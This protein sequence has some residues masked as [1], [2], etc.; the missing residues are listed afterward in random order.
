MIYEYLGDPH[1]GRKFETGVPLHRRGEREAL[2]FENFRQALLNATAEVHVTMGDLFD[3]FIVPPEVV[4]FAVSAYR[5]AAEQNP[6][7]TYVILRGNHDVSKN[8]DKASSWDI[9]VAFMRD[10]GNIWTIDDTPAVYENLLFIPY[11]P[12]NYDHLED[13]LGPE[14]DTAF[15]HFDIVDFG[16]PN[17]APTELLAR[18]GVKTLVNGHDH[19]AR[20]LDRHRVHVVVTGSMEPYTHAEDP[21]GRL[22]VTVSLGDLVGLDVRQKNVRVLLKPG[23]TLPEDLDCLSI[24]AK[25]VTVD[26]TDRTVDTTEFDNLDLDDMLSLALEGLSIKPQLLGYFHDQ[27]ALH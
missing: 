18:H 21:E 20:E 8:T 9:F 10:E 22:Y 24:V 3:K 7:T 14:I 11:D 27:K 6:N 15:G 26:D 13:Y 12:F 25:R 2:Q 17:V 5:E 19:L 23:E 4:L 1:L 16:G